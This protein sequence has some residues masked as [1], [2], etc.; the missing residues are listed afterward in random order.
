MHV[1]FCLPIKNEAEILESNLLKLLA[2]FNK[3]RF[4]FTWKIIGAINGSSDDS[5]NVFKRLK[6]DFP[7][8]LDCLNINQPGKGR[9]IKLSWRQSR[10][11]ILAFMD[12]DLAVSLEAIDSLVRPILNQEA[13]LVISSRF[14]P[15]ASAQRSWRRGVVSK[16][17]AA[18]SRLILSH[19]KKDIQCGFKVMSKAAFNRIERFLV[20]DYW[21]FDTELVVLSELAGLK[22]FEIAVNWRENRSGTKKSDIKIFQDSFRFILKLIAFRLRL[23]KIKKYFYTA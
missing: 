4:D 16:S 18:L 14:M 10:A 15:G 6:S 2:Y 17:Y 1:D 3:A 9:A 12:V 5:I 13:D 8:K 22:T 21:F 11:D 19:D 7:D 20:D 23:I